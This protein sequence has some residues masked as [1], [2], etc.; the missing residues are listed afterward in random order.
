MVARSMDGFTA[1]LQELTATNSEI[2]VLM[3]QLKQVQSDT[4]TDDT[5]KNTEVIFEIVK[6]FGINFESV[7]KTINEVVSEARHQDA[8]RQASEDKVMRNIA[9]GSQDTISVRDR[10]ANLEEKI[11]RYRDGHFRED[12]IDSK[13]ATEAVNTITVLSKEKWEYVE[14]NSKM[15]NALSWI[16]RG[17]GRSYKEAIRTMNR[18][19]S[20]PQFKD[21][22]KKGVTYEIIKDHFKEIAKKII[23]EDGNID[24]FDKEEMLNKYVNR[25]VDTEPVL[26]FWLTQKTKDD[27]A[28]KVRKSTNAWLAYYSIHKWYTETTGVIVQEQVKSVTNP[29]PIKE[30]KDIYATL[31]KWE[32]DLSQLA[33]YGEGYNYTENPELKLAA[34][35]MMFK[36]K[37]NLWESVERGIDR[38]SPA[39]E[40][41]TYML[42]SLKAAGFRRKNSGSDK[43]KNYNPLDV[44]DVQEWQWGNDNSGYDGLEG[45]DVMNLGKGKSKGKG[46]GPKGGC[47]IC[48]G[49]H[50]SSECPKGKGKSKGY[51]YYGKGGG[52]EEYKGK[53][54]GGAKGYG[55]NKGYG[56]EKGYGG[57]QKSYGKGWNEY[58][59]E[60]QGKGK[61]K[62]KGQIGY[63]SQH[64]SSWPD[65]EYST[66]GYDTNCLG[67]PTECYEVNCE[68]QPARSPKDMRPTKV[69]KQK[70]RSSNQE[71]QGAGYPRTNF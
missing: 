30:D 64:E 47:W 26:D 24:E 58:Q 15:I 19:W 55:G 51:E 11:R 53:G 71:R 61:G 39:S 17:Y 67:Y 46:K 48:G 62:S 6:K 40:K 32:T 3:N 25:F 52:Y 10:V 41:F 66:D 28:L 34:L 21:K 36:D 59:N 1:I 29:P 38:G 9:A 37:M 68:P 56:G 65:S 35:E 33:L 63:V 70:S 49:S 13:T 20:Q 23:D 2:G 44:N 45:Y 50:Y 7:I 57:Q 60:W 12:V 18:E 22:N 43:N 69:R 16:S 8:A 54:K 42:D 5:N 14:W 4:I 31:D 27:N